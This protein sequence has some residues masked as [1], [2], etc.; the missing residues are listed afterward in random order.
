M[1]DR[2]GSMQISYLTCKNTAFFKSGDFL[3]LKTNVSDNSEERTVQRV[4]LRRMF[5]FSELFTDI[6][7]QDDDGEEIGLISNIADFMPDTAKKLRDELEKTYF[8]PKIKS[9]RS[10]KERFGFST[11]KVQTDVGDAEF[12]LRDTYRSMVFAGGGRIFLVDSDGN[13]YEIPDVNK[14]DRKSYKKIELYI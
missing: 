10:L 11:W 9:I 7:V 8:V 6:S 4:H 13:R 1:T 14:L 5:P 12:T 3:G 2:N